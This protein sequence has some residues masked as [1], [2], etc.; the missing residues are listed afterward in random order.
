MTIL[1]DKPANM[2]CYKDEYYT[3][4]VDPNNQLEN[5]WG[6]QMEQQ[7][8]VPNVSLSFSVPGTPFC[9]QDRE[10][11]LDDILVALT[12]QDCYRAIVSVE[13]EN[14]SLLFKTAPYINNARG[15]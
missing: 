7:L 3:Q 2:N 15:C 12:N 6:E 9:N 1:I 5:E 4:G 10:F 11:E 14:E 13:D 8:I